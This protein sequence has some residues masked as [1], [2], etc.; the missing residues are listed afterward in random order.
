MRNVLKGVALARA[1]SRTRVPA[2]DLRVVL[3][4]LMSPQFE[5]LCDA[6]LRSLTLKTAF[7][8]ALASGRRASEVHA[9]SGLQHDVSYERDG[10]ASLVFLPEFLAKN[11]NPSDV[12]PIVSIR[13]LT[14]MVDEC[15]PDIQNCPVRALR[16][17]RHRTRQIR[18]PLQRHLLISFNPAMSK[19]VRKTTISRWI[20]T[21]IVDAYKYIDSSARNVL[22][23]LTPRAHETRAWASSLASRT[24]A[25]PQLMQTAYWRSPDVFI[26]FYLRDVA[27]VMEDGSWGLPSVVAAQVPIK[28]SRQ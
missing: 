3:H 2:W 11:Q 28:S 4:Y 9:L 19:D 17:Y 20:R 10:S 5:P 26:E 18:S 13:P 14:D 23:L 1:H 7:L 16:L 8:L 15:E 6:S 24:V 12:S 21:L 25:M 27:R 22:P